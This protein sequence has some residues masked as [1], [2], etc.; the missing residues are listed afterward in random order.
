M[1]WIK[2]NNELN[3]HGDNATGAMYAKWHVDLFDGIQYLFPEKDDVSRWILNTDTCEWILFPFAYDE[4]KEFRG[5][6]LG[7]GRFLRN[8]RRKIVVEMHVMSCPENML[9]GRVDTSLGANFPKSTPQRYHEDCGCGSDE[10][11]KLIGKGPGIGPY[12]VGDSQQ[13][14]L[15]QKLLHSKY[16]ARGRSA[17]SVYMPL[18]CL[19]KTAESK[20]VAMECM[21]EW[22]LDWDRV[23]AFIR[24]I[25]AGLK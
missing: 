13:T 9:D 4:T 23:R 11:D 22:E 8:G 6:R 12:H 19:Q 20:G 15:A 24:G 18:D 10:N 1:P 16:K 21:Q 2:A 14:F 25:K 3:N 7:Q 17:I 5:Y